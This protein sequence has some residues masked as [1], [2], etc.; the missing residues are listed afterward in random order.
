VIPRDRSKIS[1]LRERLVKRLAL[2]NDLS[3]D[4][5][6]NRDHADSWLQKALER[7]AHESEKSILFAMGR[8][9]PG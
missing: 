3:M 1:Q 5:V 7:S 6:L 9:L 8:V 4:F 2:G